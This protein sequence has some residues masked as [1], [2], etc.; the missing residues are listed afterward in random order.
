GQVYQRR[1]S[2]AE[3]R[4]AYRSAV[5]LDGSQHGCL[6]NL[7]QL[8]AHAGNPTWRWISCS[9]PWRWTPRTRPTGPSSAGCARA[10]AREAAPGV[11]AG[12]AWR[13]APGACRVAP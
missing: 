7:A 11:V 8:E 12:A 13:V 10:P 9:R 6:A 2:F 1:K 4:E 5:Q 3:A